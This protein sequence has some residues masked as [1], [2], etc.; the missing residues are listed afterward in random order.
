[1]DPSEFEDTVPKNEDILD[2]G[3][4]ELL[5]P[6]SSS[7][8]YHNKYQYID[9]TSDIGDIYLSIYNLKESLSKYEDLA[10]DV[11]LG[12]I[13][14][15]YDKLLALKEEYVIRRKQLTI[16]VKKYTT[17]YLDNNHS[18]VVTNGD[19]SSNLTSIEEESRQLIEQFKQEFD[20][21]STL[22]KHC[23]KLFLMVYNTLK[24]YPDPIPLLT[25]NM[26]VGYRNSIM[27][28]TNFEQK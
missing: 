1:M 28:V 21:L 15:N 7:T 13:S 19:D 2:A 6:S 9:L 20:F 23:E 16:K 3:T 17:T 22:T 14:I 25:A 8:S 26:E 10:L 11:V 4:L 24:E 5:L 12:E 18:S 27:V